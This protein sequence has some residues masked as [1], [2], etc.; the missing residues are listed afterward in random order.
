MDLFLFV[1]AVVAHI[2]AAYYAL[3]ALWAFGLWKLNR[4][5]R[6]RDLSAKA[7]MQEEGLPHSR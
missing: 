6:R 2:V 5:I 7:A 1:F 3:E 4:N